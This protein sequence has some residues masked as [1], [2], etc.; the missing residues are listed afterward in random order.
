[1]AAAKLWGDAQYAR[2][3]P[4]TVTLPHPE[5]AAGVISG[6]SPVNSHYAVSPF[7]YYELATPGVHQVLKSYDTLGGPHVN[8]TLVAAPAFTKSNPQITAAVLA[9]QEEANAFIGAHPQ[10]AA[11]IYI[12]LTKD[13]H[14]AAEMTKMIVD[15]DNVWTTV[16]QKVL[17]FAEF[18]HKVGR[19]KH[20]P[21]SWKDM[22]L[23][24]VQ[25]AQG[26]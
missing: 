9:A 7:Y 17:T 2:L 20:L 24:N 21:A 12:A 5:A 26:S 1:M 18:M 13:T 19:L 6:K 22:F 16:P 4:W 23:P 3:D 8:G 15:P 25:D 10:D 11:E 14:G